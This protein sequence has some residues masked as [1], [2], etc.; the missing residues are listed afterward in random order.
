MG[1]S[2][3]TLDSRIP[4][5]RAHPG[6]GIRV[7]LSIV[8]FCYIGFGLL[9]MAPANAALPINSEH[10]WGD[11]DRR[12][13]RLMTIAA[14]RADKP[15][16]AVRDHLLFHGRA[17]GLFIFVLEVYARLGGQ[18]PI[19]LQ[20]VSLLMFTAGLLLWYRWTTELFDSEVVGLVSTIFLAFSRYLLYHSTSLHH[21]P[22][23]FLFFNCT[24]FCFVRYQLDRR[25]RWLVFTAISYFV[26]CQNYYMFYIS[27][28][29][30]L[31]G[32]QWFKTNRLLTAEIAMLA[33][34]PVL[35]MATVVLQ[36][37]YAAQG[38]GDGVFQLTEVLVARTVDA[39]LEGS[40][41][42]P[43]REFVGSNEWLRYPWIVQKRISAFF[44][45][46]GFIEYL[47][48]LLVTV[49]L[50]GRRYWREHMLFLFIIP[51]ALSW[52][53][54]M[55]QH[56]VIHRFAGVYGFFAW[57]LIIGLYC[58]RA[59]CVANARGCSRRVGRLA[60]VALLLPVALLWSNGIVKH[61][62][63][64]SIRYLHNLG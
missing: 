9:R 41:W 37:M 17:P 12:V 36:A 14:E 52:N 10:E 15:F 46:A 64:Q 51:A 40:T 32:I 59:L 23:D 35:A 61:F 26:L 2:R 28:G 11:L 50:A 60:S 19:P 1:F 49:W 62:L 5:G 43:E 7:T 16:S 33:G 39:R 58:A 47:C 34:V 18:S 6:K 57:A 54:I 44:Y 13:E 63:L 31:V 21:D 48:L 22:Y 55:V 38:V 53:L 24:I 25:R 27:T 30:V 3:D 20:F 8:C 4:V 45:G 56:T 29:V 42:F